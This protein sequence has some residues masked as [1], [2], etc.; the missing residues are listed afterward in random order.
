MPDITVNIV[1]DG[2]GAITVYLSGCV[3]EFIPTCLVL[4]VIV[5]LMCRFLGGQAKRLRRE[6]QDVLACN[7]EICPEWPDVLEMTH[8]VSKME[9]SARVV[10]CRVSG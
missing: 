7:C 9:L 5:R 3:A 1:A 2:A 4:L 6:R 8:F 10:A